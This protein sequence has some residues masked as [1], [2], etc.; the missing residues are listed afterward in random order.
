MPYTQYYTGIASCTVLRISP[1][2]CGKAVASARACAGR[3]EVHVGKRKRTW[4][5]IAI[6]CF[7]IL[8]K[9]APPNCVF[10]MKMI[11]NNNG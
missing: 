5:V 6:P 1:G 4:K 10:Q 8:F 11:M 7:H 3:Y 9:L 2:I